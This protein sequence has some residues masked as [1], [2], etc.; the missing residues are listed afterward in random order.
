MSKSDFKPPGA[1]FLIF[2][3]RPGDTLKVGTICLKKCINKYIP[4]QN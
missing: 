2:K 1:L 4:C 3:L